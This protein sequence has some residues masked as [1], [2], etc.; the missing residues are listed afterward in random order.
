M[1]TEASDPNSKLE[2][3]ST[4]SETS[5]A[6][7][8]VYNSWSTTSES[9]SFYDNDD[10]LLLDSDGFG[11]LPEREPIDTEYLLQELQKRCRAVDIPSVPI[12]RRRKR[13]TCLFLNFMGS[14]KYHDPNA[15]STVRTTTTTKTDVAVASS[16]LPPPLMVFELPSSQD[17]D[18][19]LE[20]KDALFP[21]FSSKVKHS[22]DDDDLV[23]DEPPTTT[24]RPRFGEDSVNH[25]LGGSDSGSL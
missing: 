1:A 3:E 14:R 19:G 24:K 2:T 6:V 4:V 16:C 18:I 7:V 17:F 15:T 23:A 21:Q 10:T 12:L 11:S 9:I 22:I 13:P 5:A 20:E 8:S 25:G